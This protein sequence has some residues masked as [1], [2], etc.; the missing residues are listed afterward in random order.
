MNR[1]AVF[2]GIFLLFASIAFSADELEPVLYFSFDNDSGDTVEDLSDNGNDGT[3]VGDGGFDAGKYNSGL[4]LGKPDYVRVAHSETLSFTGE[5][6]VGIWV[7]LIDTANQKVIG[8]SPTSSGFVIGVNGGIYPECWPQGGAV[9]TATRGSIPVNTWA[10]LALTY[11]AESENMISYINGEE[12][13][14]LSNDGLPLGATTMNLLIGVA[15]WDP[16]QWHSAGLYDEVKLYNVALDAD[17]VKDMMEEG[18]GGGQ[19]V[20]PGS[21]LATTW[22]S[23]RDFR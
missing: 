1:I 23:V 9:L 14:R 21:K 18:I 6:T 7:S 22:G 12:V 20:S 3:I 16:A 10:H 15:P 4:S 17:Q 2:T 5:L 13:G 11:S 19:A 8:K